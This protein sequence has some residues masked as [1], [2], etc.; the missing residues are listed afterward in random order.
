MNR[1]KF[2]TIAI[3]MSNL[4]ILSI[5]LIAGTSSS[6]AAPSLVIHPWKGYD[7]NGTF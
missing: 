7:G 5:V 3:L 6:T 4:M 1:V 2:K